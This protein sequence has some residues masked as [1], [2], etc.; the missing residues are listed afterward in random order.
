[1]TK[2]PS[3]DDRRAHKGREYTRPGVT[4]NP[5]IMIQLDVS[6]PIMSDHNIIEVTTNL[7][8]CNEHITNTDEVAEIN[9]ADLRQLNFYHENVTWDEIK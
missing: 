3:P 4:S 7:K 6:K 8:D 1:M 9:E 5:E 2:P